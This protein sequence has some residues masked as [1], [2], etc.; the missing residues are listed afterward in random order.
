MEVLKQLQIVT[1]ILEFA[2]LKI[3]K[4]SSG[5]LLLSLAFNSIKFVNQMDLSN[6][7]T[8]SKLE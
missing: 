4:L 7:V 6:S 3:E 2:E 5:S 8:S 1:E